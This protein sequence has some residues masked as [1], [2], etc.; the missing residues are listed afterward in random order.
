MKQYKSQSTE[1]PVEWDLVSSS[2]TKY[3][4]TDI[5]TFPPN[6]EGIQYHNYD[7]TEYTNEEY[8]RLVLEQTRADVDYVAIMS[9]VEL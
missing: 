8:D 1:L 5:E 7:V 9:G 2:S 4:N 3:H 6:E